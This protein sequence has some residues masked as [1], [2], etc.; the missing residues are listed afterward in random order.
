ME[1]MGAM[2]ALVISILMGCKSEPKPAGDKAIPIGEGTFI[3]KEKVFKLLN[4]EL[5]QISDLDSSHIRNLE[6]SK[7]ALKYLGEASIDFVKKGASGNISSVYRG[8]YLYFRLRLNGINDLKE[9][10]YPGM[11]IV[12]FLDEYGFVINSIDIQTS[13]LIRTIGE[14]GTTDS[15]EYNGKIEL[16]IEAE[17]AIS[18]YS[19]SSTVRL[20]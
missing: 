19:I 13:D 10:F 15:Y 17:T 3:Y 6:I 7:P 8:N 20:K 5:L 4:N 11:F 12:E 18:K 16:S 1:K 14:D 2:I 9:S